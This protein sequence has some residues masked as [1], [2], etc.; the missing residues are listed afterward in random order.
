MKK[1]LCLVF[2][3]CGCGQTK[4][5]GTSQET[6]QASVKSMS[7][8]MNDKDK[9]QFAR[10]VMALTIMDNM[11]KMFIKAAKGEKPDVSDPD[12]IY[13]SLHGMTVAEINAL[14][15]EKFKKK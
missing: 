4:F 9:E 7:Q 6:V 2:L 11:P 14:A 15:A 1:L 5:D 12:K 10:S 13:S 8:G 3:F